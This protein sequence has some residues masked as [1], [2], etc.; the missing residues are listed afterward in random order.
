MVKLCRA[1]GY[2]NK[3]DALECEECHSLFDDKLDSLVNNSNNIDDNGTTLENEYQPSEIISLSDILKSNNEDVVSNIDQYTSFYNNVDSSSDIPNNNFNDFYNKEENETQQYVTDFLYSKNGEE[4]NFE[5]DENQIIDQSE[6]EI[7]SDDME[8]ISNDVSDFLY[9]SSDEQINNDN[10]QIT[11]DYN[12]YNQESVS[13]ILYSDYQEQAN[14]HEKKEKDIALDENIDVPESVS[15]FLYKN[16]PV[17]SKEEDFEE[18]V[19]D[20]NTQINV[21]TPNTDSIDNNFKQ[22]EPQPLDAFYDDNIESQSVSE[23]L[24]NTAQE[25]IND[26]LE[27]AEQEIDIYTKDDDKESNVLEEK[28]ISEEEYSNN[29][30]NVIIPTDAVENNEVEEISPSQETIDS[31][32]NNVVEEVSASQ[33][34]IDS[35]ENS[36]IINEVDVLEERDVIEENDN[37]TDIS[38]YDT[39]SDDT[40]I[41][42]TDNK[43]D[44]VLT[45][46]NVNTEINDDVLLTEDSIDKQVEEELEDATFMES[47]NINDIL[48]TNSSTEDEETET[49]DN[50]DVK[51]KDGNNNDE[52]TTEHT[53]TD[54]LDTL[55]QIFSFTSFG[56][57]ELS[58]KE[59]EKEYDNSN[60]QDNNNDDTGEDIYE[61]VTEDN[62][63]SFKDSNIPISTNKPIKGQPMNFNSIKPME[64]RKKSVDNKAAAMEDT[65]LE[66]ALKAFENIG[67]PTQKEE[68]KKSETV[69]YDLSSTPSENK[70]EEIVSAIPVVDKEEKKRKIITKKI[71][72]EKSNNHSLL[73]RSIAISAAI[74]CIVVAIIVIYSV[75]KEKE[76]YA[77]AQ[78]LAANNDI[79]YNNLYEGLREKGYSEDD[80][81]KAI[82]ALNI[83]FAENAVNVA[84]TAAQDSN[85]LSSKEE[86][87]KILESKGFANSE[88]EKAMSSIDWSKYLTIYID[89]CISKS[90][91]LDKN[92]IITNIENAK[93]SSTEVDY[94]KRNAE[95]SKL[96][97]KNL[98][99]YLGD[100]E[101]HTKEEAK[102]FLEEKGY[103]D[104][105]I[106]KTFKEYEWDTYAYQYLTKYL[107]QQEEAGKT[108][109]SSRNS[110]VKILED[111]KFD[112]EDI[113]LVIGRFDFASY[114]TSK[115]DTI[116]ENGK[117][118]DKNEVKKSLEADGYTE[119]E[120][121]TALKATDWNATA[122]TSLDSLKD[123]TLSKADML[124]KLTDAGY[125]ESE[126]E[127]AKKKYVWADQLKKYVFDYL[128]PENKTG[129]EEHLRELLK[130]S[131]Y[132]ED[133]IIDFFYHSISSDYFKNNA[134][135]AVKDISSSTTYSRNAARNFLKNL[136]Y[137]NT[138]IN[139]VINSTDWEE[140]AKKYIKGIDVNSKA[141]ARTALQKEDFSS[142]EIE[143]ALSSIN[144][145]KSRCLT[146]AKS[147]YAQN[148]DDTKCQDYKKYKRN[149]ETSIEQ[150][151]RNGDYSS[152][153]IKYVMENLFVPAPCNIND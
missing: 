67:K 135:E 71:D 99:T 101:L 66:D 55:K 47:I 113:E 92:T 15:E 109:E 95:W 18:S 147:I 104:E 79:S 22:D 88:I 114:A 97:K 65:E 10:T 63:N 11:E 140:V 150:T 80:S 36:D 5:L 13:D 124:K 20:Y 9:G 75:N 38:K 31:T 21:D 149:E 120:I 93:F 43:E 78:R 96:A 2:I 73:K 56:S 41:T 144:D 134:K 19:S 103:S 86:V 24:Y 83:D 125:S 4:E 126:I 143:E 27:K 102:L 146:W 89:A 6:Q 138:E 37:S 7:I 94:V 123:K 69:V 111:A 132:T 130:D 108:I 122:I 51:T 110:Y 48:G 106:D 116:A 91:E 131:G 139:A 44:D 152:D 60:T 129:S 117:F 62:I 112:Q 28:N 105:D 35:A 23:F 17:E 25:N 87:S 1:C 100:E 46:E 72:K 82:Q 26:L 34:T 58:K 118:I 85:K 141:E 52:V 84:Y 151:L 127:Y 153:E 76:L 40:A 29:N 30:D 14:T 68:E 115:I 137:S 142:A 12:N 128:E 119:E 39:L 42:T 70:E 64:I 3:D 33:D 49:S 53:K 16:V 59:L 81:F 32:E 45:E 148:S 136:N 74:A 50:K 107:Q 98:N 57:R 90:K 54:L 77:Y 61:T 133:E 121:E 145:W 8:I